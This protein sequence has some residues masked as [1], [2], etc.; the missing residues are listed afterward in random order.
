[1][2]R[3][4]G[5]DENGHTEQVWWNMIEKHEAS[6][7]GMEKAAGAKKQE[8]SREEGLRTNLWRCIVWK[9][10]NTNY[11]KYESPTLRSKAYVCRRDTLS[12][13]VQR[14]TTDEEKRKRSLHCY[15]E[16]VEESVTLS[17][18]KERETRNLINRPTSS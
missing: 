11:V 13:D 3:R 4:K 9:T 14:I 12:R 16:F 15:Y 18:R 5:Y 1:M 8:R 6:G 10:G 17:L 7:L 2:M